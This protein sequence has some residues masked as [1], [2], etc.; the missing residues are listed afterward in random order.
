MKNKQPNKINWV[1][2]LKTYFTKGDIRMAKKKKHMK[3]CSTSLV[4]WE[5]QNK[6]SVRYYYIPIGIAK[7]KEEK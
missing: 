3:K 7:I 4:I 6:I 1:I 5:M 2:D